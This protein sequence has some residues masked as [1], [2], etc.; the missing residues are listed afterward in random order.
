[1]NSKDIDQKLCNIVLSVVPHF[2][3]A[4]YLPNTKK[5]SS[6]NYYLTVKNDTF[7]FFVC[8]C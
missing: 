5:S 4:L 3:I 8:T 7:K 1:M 2:V 6:C